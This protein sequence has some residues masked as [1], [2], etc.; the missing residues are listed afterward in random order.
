LCLGTVYAG[1]GDYM[2]AVSEYNRT[3]ELDPTMDVAYLNLGTAYEKLQQFSDAERIYK[4]AVDLRPDY[5]ASYSALGYY[6]FR[7]VQYEQ[8]ERMFTQVV[9]LAPDSYLGYS[10]LGVS[11]QA[12]HQNV[13]ASAAFEKSLSIRPNYAAAANLGALRFYE[14]D[15]PGAARAFHQA[16]LLDAHDYR[17]WGNLGAALHWAGQQNESVKAY[18]EARRRAEER[19]KV[20]PRDPK[21]LMSLAEYNGSLGFSDASH[22]LL[23][24]ALKQA[25]EDPGLLFKAAVVYDYNL[26]RRD[27]ALQSLRKAIERNFPWDEIDRSPSLSDLRNDPRFAEL[28]KLR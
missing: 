7:K 14:R 6:Y 12:Q 8:A 11:Y 21:I 25:P 16:V 5:W 4:R 17:V 22:A 13:Q 9:H 24:D 15:Y 20:N 18:M 3:L 23:K 1:T 26:K 27:D 10:D 28:R 2:K 19:L